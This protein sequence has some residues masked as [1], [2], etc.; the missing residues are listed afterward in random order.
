MKRE[1]FSTTQLLT[2]EKPVIENKF[3]D[4]FESILFLPENSNR[5][6]EG[7]LR[8]K[9][10]FKKSYP[11]KPL[12]TIVTVTYNS[13][14]FLEETI[15]GVLNQTY[16]NIEYIVIDGGSSDQTLDII[17]KY[18]GAID[19]WVSEPDN[20]MY[21]ALNK[22]FTL[23]S[24]ELVNFCNS[25]DLFY[26]NGIIKKIVT[27]Y[28]QENFDFCYGIS[29]F[30]DSTGM[31][32]SYSY[33]L[34]FKE[35]YIVTLGLPFVQP[36]SFWKLSLM[37]KI[38]LFNLNYKI[39]SDYDLLSRLLK[40]SSKIENMS[41]SIIKFRKY[42]T[43]FGDKNT[44]IARQEAPIIRNNFKKILCMSN[45]EDKVFSILDRLFQKVSRIIKMIQKGKK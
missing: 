44:K 17:K 35:R 5:K 39:V 34:D 7:G 19:Y 33:P 31:H 32:L 22:A 4:K 42:G 18:E 20:G 36:T 26:S 13:E 1:K 23:A 16:E 9:S 2:K 10:Y 24:G 30:I 21:D 43:S 3:E 29:Q 41:F 14:Q 6:L 15:Q 38:G 40:E 45:F 8:T 25:D 28:I 11:G 12:V 27:K 37:K